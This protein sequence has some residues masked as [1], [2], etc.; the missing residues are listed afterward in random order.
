MDIVTCTESLKEIGGFVGLVSAAG[1]IVSGLTL[2]VGPRLPSPKM[3]GQLIREDSEKSC[4][5]CGVLLQVPAELATQ[6]GA[7]GRCSTCRAV[8]RVSR[9]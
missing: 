2:L 4:P 1:Q 5:N 3:P 7:R 9:K 6:H 8:L